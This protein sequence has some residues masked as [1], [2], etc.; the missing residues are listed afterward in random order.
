MRKKTKNF[1]E[2]VDFLIADGYEY[3]EGKHPALRGRKGG[4]GF[5][6]SV[7]LEKD[8]RLII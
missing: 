4:A 1:K 3:K 7:F 2:L 8:I 5:S 6:V